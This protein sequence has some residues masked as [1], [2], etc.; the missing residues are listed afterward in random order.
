MALMDEVNKLDAEIKAENDIVCSDNAEDDKMLEGN[1]NAQNSPIPESKMTQE[2]ANAIVNAAKNP[3]DFIGLKVSTKINELI[4]NDDNVKD[5][6]ADVAEDTTMTGIETFS[7]TNKKQR[8]ANYY[9]LNEK[10]IAPMGGDKT[11][12]KG[13]Q[14]SIVVMRR[15]FWILIMST[16]GFF[17]IAPLTVMVELF[18]GLTFKKIEKEEIT[19]EGDKK[20]KQ[21]IT[22]TKLG[23]AGSI[24][25][26]VFGLL[27][28]IAVAT[29]NIFFPMI[30]LYISCCVFA[31][32]MAI[33]VV[34]GFDSNRMKK[35]KNK[36][37]T[38]PD[39]QATIVVEE[40]E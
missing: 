8:K 34:C 23:R 29:G 17:Y 1:K 28:D 10:D 37:G 15:F 2:Q 16:L 26:L 39:T 32:L 19:T 36:N 21:Y 25:G 7:T 3:K 6:I 18:Q 30:Y 38:T 22:R 33:N 4:E 14:V 31:V 27:L 13:Q 12:S 11:S 40:D 35:I 24:M 20:V 9:D 5:K